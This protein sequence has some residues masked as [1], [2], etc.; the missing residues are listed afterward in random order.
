M[1]ATVSSHFF[2]L[3]ES[4]FY[5]VIWTVGILWTAA[6]L[7]MAIKEAHQ[8]TFGKTILVFLIT[9]LGMYLVLIIATIAY[10]MFA[11]LLSFIVMVYN[12]LRLKIM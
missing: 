4:A 5:G 2:S 10:S 3:D 11:Q 6:V 12:E 8:Y 7:F 1:V 9:L